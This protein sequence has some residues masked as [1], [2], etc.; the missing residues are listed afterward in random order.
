MAHTG[1][2]N[3]PCATL[4]TAGYEDWRPAEEFRRVPRYTMVERSSCAG[5]AEFAEKMNATQ[6]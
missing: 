3:K 6:K 4:R 2:V 5:S 1:Q